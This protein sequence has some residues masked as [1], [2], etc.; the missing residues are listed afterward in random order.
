MEKAFVMDKDGQILQ[1]QGKLGGKTRALKKAQARVK[2]LEDAIKEATKI[3][4][5]HRELCNLLSSLQKSCDNCI[6][7]DSC[8]EVKLRNILRIE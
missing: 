5:D 4:D 7:K 1:L 3:A 8:W 6:A 2:L